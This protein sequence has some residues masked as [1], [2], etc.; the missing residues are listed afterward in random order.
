MSLVW[1]WGLSCWGCWWV[2]VG[3]P[4]DERRTEMRKRSLLILIYQH[5]LEQG[6]VWSRVLLNEVICVC[7][8]ERHGWPRLCHRLTCPRLSPAPATWP[9]RWPWTRRPTAT[10]GSMR[11][12]IMLTWR[13][14]CV[15]T[16][17]TTTTSTRSIPSSS[18]RPRVRVSAAPKPHLLLCT[19]SLS[20]LDVSGTKLHFYFFILF[21]HV[22]MKTDTREVEERGGE[23]LPLVGLPLRGRKH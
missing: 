3:V 21:V 17:A 1:R 16:R 13:W 18:A 11:P 23:S 7:L 10:W 8:K 9:Q 20:Y 12:A 22:K 2:C 4:Q 19:M 15:S 14:C 5:L 6:W